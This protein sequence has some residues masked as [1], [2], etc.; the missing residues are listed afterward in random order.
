MF[1]IKIFHFLKG[2]VI[3][4]ISG[5]NKEEFLNSIL[6]LDIQPRNLYFDENKIFAELTVDDF[7]KLRESKLR[8]NIHIEKKYGLMF[9]LR[10]LKKRIAFLVGLIAFLLLFVLG[11]QFIWTVS[12]EGVE[13]CDI[14]QLEEAVRLSGLHEGMFKKNLKPAV[15]MKNIILNNTDGICWAWVYVKG[16][17]A[18]VKVRENIIPPEVFSPDTPCDIIAMRNGIIK[19]VIARHGKCLVSENQAVAAGDTIISGSYEFINEPG[20]QVHAQGDVEAYT[21]HIRT[22]TYK[23][24]YCYK[25][26]TGRKRNFLTLRMFKW[27]I[28]LYINGKVNFDSFDSETMEYD[29]TLG[30]DFYTGIGLTKTACAEYTTEKEPI[31]YDTAVEFAKN[32]L[33]REISRELL[34][35]AKL[36]DKN[37]DVQKIDEE[38]I[39]VTL[40]MNFIE[41]IGTEKR[42]EEVTFIEPKTD[43]TAAGD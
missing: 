38:T 12:Y 36:T 19:R 26:Y 41:K 7:F 33:E 1:L 24:F 11:S 8:A 20:Y 27:K 6:E 13:S 23:Q 25:K 42:I 43:R 30:K 14:H 17:K 28:P 15:E 9:V 10:R 29:L 34:P 40:T 35:G 21:E 31:S 4:S 5:Y 39:T 2:Y 16:T 37:V 32:E 3:L 22:G 18:V